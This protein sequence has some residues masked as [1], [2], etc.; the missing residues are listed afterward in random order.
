MVDI[1]MPKK[2]M[3]A[4]CFT[5]TEVDDGKQDTY[6]YML[7]LVSWVHQEHIFDRKTSLNNI[8]SFV[9]RIN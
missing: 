3:N 1:I 2:L 9:K 7:K 8:I 5:Q 6:I 4:I